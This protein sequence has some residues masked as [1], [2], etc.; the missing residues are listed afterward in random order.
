MVGVCLVSHGTAKQF[1]RA[2]VPFYLPTSKEEVLISPH[3]HRDFCYFLSFFFQDIFNNNHPNHYERNI[4]DFLK[5]HTD[6]YGVPFKV[7]TH[8]LS[9]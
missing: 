9:L 3:P 5:A 6:F 4:I 1:C 2:V 8:A 7:L